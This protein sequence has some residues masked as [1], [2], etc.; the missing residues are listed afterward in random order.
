MIPMQEPRPNCKN[1]HSLD[2]GSSQFKTFL[3]DKVT[4]LLKL[5]QSGQYQCSPRQKGD[6]ELFSKPKVLSQDYLENTAG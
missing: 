1:A 4:I 6:E 5:L 3:L 2:Q